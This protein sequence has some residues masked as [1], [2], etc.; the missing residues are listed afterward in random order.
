MVP[1]DL[2]RE[3][4]A[5]VK[6]RDKTVNKTWAAWWRA[7]AQATVAVLRKAQRDEPGVVWF[8]GDDEAIKRWETREM[9][10]AETLEAK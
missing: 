5:T 6:Q 2:K 1:D 7:Q 4:Y 3:V 8:A 10:F 9:A